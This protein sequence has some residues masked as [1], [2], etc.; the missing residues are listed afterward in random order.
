LVRLD[1]LAIAPSKVPVAV[2]PSV[3]S[4]SDPPPEIVPA[5][6]L[7]RPVGPS[8]VSVMAPLAVSGAFSAMLPP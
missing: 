3:S 5:A 4:V 1:A 8:A 2:A 6:L 7:D